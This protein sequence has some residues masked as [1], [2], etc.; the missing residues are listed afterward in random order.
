[1][2]HVL[3]QADL[4]AV[5]PGPLEPALAREFA[6]LADV[7]SRGGATVYRFSPASVRRALDAGRTGEDLLALLAR[8]SRTEV[9]QPLHY[10]VQDTARRHGRVRVGAASAY[11]RAD[12]EGALSEL[13]ADRRAAGLR[14]RRLAPTVLAAQAP[15]E[16]VLTTL[17]SL[18]LAPAAETPEGDVLL[19]RPSERRTPPRN[20]P[21]PVSPLPPSPGAPAL[22]AAVRALRAA[23]EAA[24]LRARTAERESTDLGTAPPLAPMDPAGVLAVLRDA[25]AGRHAAWIGYVDATGHASTRLV[26]PLSVEAGRIHAFDRGAEQVRTFSVHRVSGVAV[27]TPDGTPS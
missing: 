6:L 23:D 4:T 5:A 12:D 20:R 24:S 15:P 2:D 13:L 7:E 21:R 1:V 10:L 16:T 19:R 25:A 3:L 26:E 14:L 9:P 17:R 22:M 27:A 18:G 11:V 8:H